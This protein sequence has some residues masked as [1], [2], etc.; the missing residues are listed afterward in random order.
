MCC[1]FSF[2][3]L[4]L[5]ME[6]NAVTCL[7]PEVIFKK[8]KHIFTCIYVC[9]DIVKESCFVGKNYALQWQ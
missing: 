4:T 6:M 9:D 5:G 7:V 2:P 1:L 8:N 3:F